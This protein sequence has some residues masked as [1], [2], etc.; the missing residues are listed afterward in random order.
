M[1]Y[2]ALFLSFFISTLALADEIPLRKAG[3]WEIEMIN[4][5]ELQ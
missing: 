5:D 2:F 3:L 4:N 1:K